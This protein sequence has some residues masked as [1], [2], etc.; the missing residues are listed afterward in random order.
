[1]KRCKHCAEMIREE[2]LYCVFCHKK[3]KGIPYRRLSTILMILTLGF[4][5]AAHREE[6]KKAGEDI[7]SRYKSAVELKNTMMD[8]A[9]TAPNRINNVRRYRQQL[10]ELSLE[11]ESLNNA[12][13]SGTIPNGIGM[14]D[15]K[16]AKSLTKY[17]HRVS[18]LFN[19]L[20]NKKPK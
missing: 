20:E 2:A 6:I 1:M 19:E 10:H 7:Q 12:A 11:L 8:L 18:A 17:R 4:Y 16:K 15:S 3:V 9:T 13:R 14:A 5:G